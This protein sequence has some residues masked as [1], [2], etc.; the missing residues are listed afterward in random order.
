MN[1]AFEALLSMGEEG[2]N[3]LAMHY[4]HKTLF[5]KLDTTELY[6]HPMNMV[7]ENTNILLLQ[8]HPY[9]CPRHE[10]H[11][12]TTS[13]TSATPSTP[14]TPTHTTHRHGEVF[15]QGRMA[16]SASSM[17]TCEEGHGTNHMKHNH[18]S[19]KTAVAIRK[20]HEGTTASRKTPL[21]TPME[22][23]SKPKRLVFHQYKIK[24]EQV[25]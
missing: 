20:Q 23:I 16:H 4:K 10:S 1:A 5:L 21:K 12:Y 15:S 19:N 24:C 25:S 11:M 6:H 9:M 22:K 2:R 13:A 14:C 17:S 18:M 3:I 8:Q 7:K